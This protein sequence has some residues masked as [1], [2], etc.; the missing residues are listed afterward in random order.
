MNL[1]KQIIA[2]F[3]KLAVFSVLFLGAC[4]GPCVVYYQSPKWFIKDIDIDKAKSKQF[5]IALK[6]ED[7]DTGEK[8]AVERYK[9]V[10]TENNFSGVQYHLPGKHMSYS[11]GPGEESAQIKVTNEE[12]GSQLIR[13]FVTGDTPWTSLS[14]YRVK[15]NEIHPLRYAMSN[16]WFL[17]GTIIC[18]F[19]VVLLV[20]PIGRSINRILG[21]PPST[22]KIQT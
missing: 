11:W 7:S 14:E 9:F 5:Y 20:R 12:Q 22:D 1:L 13:V 18:P 17:L 2:G 4:V 19:L 21:L 8:I 10:S 3:L 16:P 15:N 6:S